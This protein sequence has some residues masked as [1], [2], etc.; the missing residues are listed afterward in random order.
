MHDKPIVII[1]GPTA[2]GKSFFVEELAKK[3][4]LKILNADTG[5]MYSFTNVGVAKP[6]EI[7]LQDNFFFDLADEKRS[8]TSVEYRRKAID[9]FRSLPSDY[10]AVF[11]GGSFFY[12]K[13]LLFSLDVKNAQPV[14]ISIEDL[15][16]L[17][18]FSPEADGDIARH[19][20]LNKYDCARASVL[21]ASDSYRVK[22]ALQIIKDSGLLPSSLKEVFDPVGKK[23][24]LICINPPIDILTD[25]I[26][27][28]CDEM[29][30][31]WKKE[32]A[33]FNKEELNVVKQK[34]FIGY[35]EIFDL[36]SSLPSVAAAEELV[37]KIKIKTRAYAK[38]Q[39]KF[40]N[41]LRR[42]L[43]SEDPCQNNVEIIEVQNIDQ[44]LKMVDNL[45]TKADF[46]EK[47][48]GIKK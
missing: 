35:G 20:L 6:A 21:G 28:R 7:D 23:I 31:A 40:W 8:I 46:D 15:N 36:N 3:F 48:I 38:R 39:K 16:A 4:K 30:E 25:R 27:R 18:K 22:R 34:K 45:A 41:K 19:E 33:N 29:I 2:S 10:S 13:H 32:V 1:A 17:E 12:L 5:Q 9:F 42:E 14:Q 11:V 37:L 26:N 47:K 43:Q 24:I 44:A